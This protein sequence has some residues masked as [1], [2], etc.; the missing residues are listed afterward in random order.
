MSVSFVYPGSQTNPRA[1]N[2]I[3][4][5]LRPGQFVV[6]VGTNGSGKSTP[7][8]LLS[9]GDFSYPQAGSSLRRSMAILS[10]D[11]LIYPGFSLGENIGLGYTLLLSGADATL[12][13]AG[14]AGAAEGVLKELRCPVEVNSGEQQRIAAGVTRVN[15]ARTFVKFRS[16][17]IGLLAVD[18]PSS[19]LDVEAE[20]APRENLLKE[21][22]GKTNIFVT[23]LMLK[24]GKFVKLGTHKWLMEVDGEY[25]KLYD[26]QVST[27]QD[28]NGAGIDS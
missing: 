21:C 27:S 19:T 2:Y 3:N 18:E 6:L 14:K 28:D 13:T 4:L 16:G 8:K 12:E 26:I 24:E 7:V 15:E 17:K 11:N 20:S 9:P 1:L 5:T 25:K 23:P 22:A 10:Q